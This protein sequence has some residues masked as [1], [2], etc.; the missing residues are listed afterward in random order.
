MG[1]L[2]P[3]YYDSSIASKN[4]PLH[5]ISTNRKISVGSKTRY[6]NLAWG[7]GS[8]MVRTIATRPNCPSFDSE[9][10]QKIS[11]GKIYDVTEVNEQQ[12]LEENRQWQGKVD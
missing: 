6:G 9:H 2:N 1:G 8:T 7:Q 3:G 10:S 5:N 4:L 12:Y 11:K